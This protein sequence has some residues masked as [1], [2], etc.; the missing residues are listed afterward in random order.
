MKMLRIPI[1][2]TDRPKQL[3]LMKSVY[4]PLDSVVKIDVQNGYIILWRKDPLDD[5]L[6]Q[7]TMTS[8]EWNSCEYHCLGLSVTHTEISDDAF[9]TK[10]YNPSEDHKPLKEGDEV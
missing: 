10:Q 4:I 9:F 3:Q 6:L 7:T 2:N 5:G 1:Y 8:E